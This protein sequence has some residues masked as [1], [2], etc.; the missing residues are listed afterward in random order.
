MNDFA[1]TSWSV[2]QIE[3]TEMKHYKDFVYGKGTQSSTTV[4]SY[5]LIIYVK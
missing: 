5:F 2:I 3:E 4:Y 1:H